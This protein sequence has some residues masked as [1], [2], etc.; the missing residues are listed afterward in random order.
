MK[1]VVL[2][3]RYPSQDSPYSHMFVHTRNVEYVAKGHEVIVLVPAKNNFEYEIDGVKVILADVETLAKSLENADRVMIHLLM[4]RF[5]KSVDAEYLYQTVLKE[6]LPTL[7]FIH[8]V[9]SQTIWHS[10][11]EDIKWHSPKTVARW[12]YRDCYLIKRMIKTLKEFNH[13]NVPCKFV[14]PSKWMLHESIR[15]T[16]IDLTDKSLVIPNGIDTEHF[17]FTDH[18]ENRHKLLSIRP[19]IYRGKY[20]VDLLL[21]TA[22]KLNDEFKTTLYGQGQDESIIADTASKLISQSE[23]SLKPEFINQKDIPKIHAE[24]GIYLAVTRMDAQG[25]SMCEAM[26]SGMPTVSFD[27]CAIPEFIVHGNTGLLA[28]SYD[29]EQYANLVSELVE[30]QS[31]FQTIANNARNAMEAIDVRKTTEQEL[32]ANI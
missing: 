5:D 22:S 30:D 23:F 17:R 12:L 32:N 16:G 1:I 3:G 27:T 15:H 14:T 4:H 18:W 26:A 11:R 21:E 2:T 31:L 6:R 7:F 28:Q 24:H 29:V 8:G 9:E 19:L 20:A 10:R 13:P 25:V